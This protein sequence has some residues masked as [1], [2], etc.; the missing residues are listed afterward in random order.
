MPMAPP[1][2]V[3]ALGC[4][5][6]GGCA[7]LR[8]FCSRFLGLGQDVFLLLGSSGSLSRFPLLWKQFLDSFRILFA[9]RRRRNG[10]KALRRRKSCYRRRLCSA[11]LGARQVFVCHAPSLPAQRT[12]FSCLWKALYGL[13]IGI[14]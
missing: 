11:A 4:R 13:S 6:C 3:V 10:L 12:I 1:M 2:M 8:C 14:G 7:G 9:K 5:V